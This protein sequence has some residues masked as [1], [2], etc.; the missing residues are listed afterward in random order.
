MVQTMLV[1]CLRFVDEWDPSRGAGLARF[2]IFRCYD[3]GKKYVHSELA[4]G[5]DEFGRVRMGAPRVERCLSSMLA[6][7][8]PYQSVARL[9]DSSVAPEQERRL[10]VREAAAKSAALALFYEFGDGERAALSAISDEKLRRRYRVGKSA[11][12]ANVKRARR[13]LVVAATA[14]YKNQIEDAP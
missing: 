3:C 1:S 11:G 7:G 9:L 13:R 12:S 10:M 8:Q 4:T 5:R 6:P 14:A 2:V